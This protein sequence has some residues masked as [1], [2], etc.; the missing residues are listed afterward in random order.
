MPPDDPDKLCP[1]C[2]L[3]RMWCRCRN[4]ILL[5]A[6]LWPL[7][8]WAIEC[9]HAPSDGGAW[10]WR[11]VDGEKCWYEGHRVVSKDQLHWARQEKP[12][13]EKSPKPEP[14][15]KQSW[16][17][18]V[19]DNAPTAEIYFPELKPGNGLETYPPMIWHQPWLTADSIMHWPLL[20]DIDRVPFTAWNKRIGQ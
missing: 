1:R 13:P 12:P 6:M 2:G 14:P 3:P 16:L 7:P 10:T 4:L 11:N 5:I 8:T 20:L 15:P 18:R 17:E 9:H 19:S